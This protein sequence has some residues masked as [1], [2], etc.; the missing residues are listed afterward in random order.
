MSYLSSALQLS[1]WRGAFPVVPQPEGRRISAPLVLVVQP[2]AE[3][4][5][6][7]FW[8]IRVCPLD[9]SRT[10]VWLTSGTFRKTL[11]QSYFI[12]AIE[13]RMFP[14]KSH[15]SSL[16]NLL[17]HAYAEMLRKLTHVHYVDWDFFTN[18]MKLKR[19]F[20]RVSELRIVSL[21]VSACL[22]ILY[23]IPRQGLE[24]CTY[25]SFTDCHSGIQL[26]EGKK[27]GNFHQMI[28]SSS[29]QQLE[30]Q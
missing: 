26:K 10:G 6:A 3:E 2:W 17:Y 7:A 25:L 30:H 14:I 13:E 21:Q 8:Q 18:E 4:N 22:S 11:K 29:E 5:L 20:I 28:A 27:V 15:R 19:V 1:C 23:S 24:S 12:L 9:K 16:S